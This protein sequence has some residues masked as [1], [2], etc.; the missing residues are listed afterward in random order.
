MPNTQSAKKSMKTDEKSRISN[1]AAK[2]RMTTLRKNLIE[3]IGN[4]KLDE[5]K[6][7]FGEYSSLLD[8]AVK[9]NIVKANAANR[10]KSRLALR[11]KKLS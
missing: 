8:K 9:K 5:S 6:K 7:L 10:R 11:M 4:E 1:K 2:S 3:A